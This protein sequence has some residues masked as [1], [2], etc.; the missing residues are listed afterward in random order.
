[1]TDDEEIE[2]DDWAKPVDC[3]ENLSFHSRLAQVRPTY[4]TCTLIS[5]K[6]RTDAK[7]FQGKI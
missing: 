5:Q 7:P 3:F 4:P 2:E 6:M 1:M